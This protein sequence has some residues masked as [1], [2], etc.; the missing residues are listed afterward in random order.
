MATI[1]NQITRTIPNV[2]GDLRTKYT[3]N[4]SYA[5]IKNHALDRAK[6]DL[7]SRHSVEIQAE[8]DMVELV[9]DWLCDQ[10]CVYILD[11]AIDFYKSQ[12]LSDSVD[13]HNLTYHDKVAACVRQRGYLADRAR[14]GL[15]YAVDLIL[16]TDTGPVAVPLTSSR[17]VNR[18]T[19][20]PFAKARPWR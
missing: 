6:R 15:L 5:D 2:E 19:Q 8:A 4:P 3:S 10:A 18:I 7:Y 12:A 14:D 13:E 17:D 20:D 9:M 1:N 11:A 16:T